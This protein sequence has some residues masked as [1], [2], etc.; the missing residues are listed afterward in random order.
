MLI[1]KMVLCAFLLATGLLLVS[2]GSKALLPAAPAVVPE[3]SLPPAS[4]LTDVSTLYATRCAPC[5]GEKRQ[6]R[7]GS[8]GAL[9]PERLGEKSDEA[10]RNTISG[11]IP[12]TDMPAFER[13]L[14]PEEIEAL[15]RFIKYTSP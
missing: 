13:T 2:C 10:I 4:S 11:G 12:F 3:P 14:S 7:Y 8:G 15:M 5:H 1:K 9:T 6:G